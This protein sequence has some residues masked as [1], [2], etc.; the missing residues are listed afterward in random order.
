MIGASIHLKGIS[1]SFDGVQVLRDVDLK[2]NTGEF[3]SLLG[4]SGCGK[5]T[6]LRILA[7]FEDPD[8]GAVILNNEEITAVPPNRRPVNTVFQSY[9]L[10]PHLS[11]FENIAFSLRL[12]KRPQ[13]EVTERVLYYLDLVRLTGHEK[14][15]IT[16]L[17]GGQ[18]QRVAIARALIND[19]QVLLLDEPLS[20]LD[21]KLRQDLLF[22]LDSIH[23]SV[24]ITFVY[25]T[26]DQE[27]ALGVSDR[28]AV[29]S[30]GK[31]IQIGTPSEI[32]E[33]PATRFVAQFIGETNFLPGATTNQLYSLRP[34]RIH[35]TYHQPSEQPGRIIKHGKL[36]ERVYNG[37]QVRAHISLVDGQMLKAVIPIGPGNQKLP[38]WN[39]QVYISWDHSEMVLL[40]D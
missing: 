35:V 37:Y 24:G 13:S 28:I 4:P 36:T 32:Y 16:Q 39:E 23:D 3:F 33:Y 30:E 10:F 2:I 20:A 26:H 1:K 6:L 38:D 34:E 5:T 22:E 18:K 14:K 40:Q 19:P 11:V 12:K 7:G 29:M 25:V 9:A 27:E 31:V 8:I 17:S 21:A 15:K